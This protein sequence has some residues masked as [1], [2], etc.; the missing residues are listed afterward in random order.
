[1]N[2]YVLDGAYDADRNEFAAAVIPPLEAV[3]QF[4]AQTSLSPVDETQTGGGLI[5]IVTK[6]GS[7]TYHGSAFEYV[8]N[9]FSDANSYF[10]DPSLGVPIYR[11]N[12]Y[13]ASLGGPLA[14]SNAST[15]GLPLTSTGWNG[16]SVRMVTPP[17]WR[18]IRQTT[19]GMLEP[20]RRTSPPG[21]LP[22]RK[23]PA[24]T[25]CA[26]GLGDACRRFHRDHGHDYPGGEEA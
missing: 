4:R 1:M 10:D 9:Q 3:S 26:G 21:K 11:R 18:A 25:S 5:D 15:A 14:R 13:G 23:P 6:S 16:A 20:G 2:A 19:E 22:P 24:A 7:R 12:Q 8:R 17:G